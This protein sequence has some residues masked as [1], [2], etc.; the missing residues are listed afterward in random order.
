MSRFLMFLL[1]FFFVNVSG[2]LKG[3]SIS[4]PINEGLL[5]H[6]IKEGIDSV[7]RL[8]N[9]SSLANDSILYVA[10]KHHAR[11]LEKKNKLSHYE[12]GNIGY[13]TPQERA[14][15]YG[16][17]PNYL[18]GENVAQNYYLKA[19]GKKNGE[20]T[21]HRSYKTLAK[22][23]VTQWVNSPGHFKNIIT[24]T[25]NTTGLAV[26][27]NPLD[28]SVFAVQ[29]FG[30]ALFQYQFQESKVF[31]PYSNYKPSLP[32]EAFDSSHMQLH[33]GKH[34]WNTKSSTNEERYI[35]GNQI[36]DAD[37]RILK[38]EPKGRSI[39]VYTKGVEHLSQIIKDKKDGL[40]IEV[41]KYEEYHC[42]N[43]EYYLAQ[44]RRNKQCEYSGLLLKPAYFKKLN[45]RIQY[46][47]GTKFRS[48]DRDYP[49]Y[50]AFFKAFQPSLRKEFKY[51]LGRLPRNYGGYLEFNLVY[52]NQKEVIRVRHLTD[53]CGNQIVDFQI[54]PFVYNAPKDTL[55]YDLPHIDSTYFF[56]FPKAIAEYQMK[57]ITPLLYAGFERYIINDVEIEAYSSIEGL[58]SINMQ[59]QIDRANSIVQAL[60]SRQDL[61]LNP[62]IETNTNW[63][64]FKDQL[65]KSKDY[66]YLLSYHETV[67]KQ[68]VD[69]LLGLDSNYASLELML[70]SQ[71]YASIKLS[72]YYNLKDYAFEFFREYHQHYMEEFQSSKEALNPALDNKFGSLLS[73]VSKAI[74]EGLIS[75][76]KLSYF[77]PPRHKSMPSSLYA[78]F[79]L[80]HQFEILEEDPNRWT[81][82]YNLVNVPWNPIPAGLINNAIVEQFNNYREQNTKLVNM[83]E[84]MEG[85][86][87]ELS[88]KENYETVADSFM[89]AL[90]ID[91]LNEV[92]LMGKFDI[93]ERAANFVFEFYDSRKVDSGELLDIAELFVFI[94]DYNR[95]YKLLEPYVDINNPHLG[96]ISL[97]TKLIYQNSNEYPGTP[98]GDW[99]KKIYP[100]FPKEQWCQ[101]FVGPCNISF[102]VFDDKS[103][104]DLYCKQCA[105]FG[106]YAI[107]PPT[108]GAVELK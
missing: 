13:E 25:Y 56:Y 108:D 9:L 36:I 12:R 7:R 33:K 2:Q 99:L 69:S 54:P 53:V 46:R 85:H 43:P 70:D 83:A 84:N 59:L 48:W 63:K 79:V 30:Q 1:L 94:E 14:S 75:K 96:I 49:F 105:E 68:K 11:Y 66:K 10:A 39:K 23:I 17:G 61:L 28:R 87:L 74:M 55:V 102:Q 16:I 15:S 93:F 52:L 50:T 22:A 58:N 3:Q 100:L 107:N 73:S 67:Q 78:Y 44:S 89:L 40:A 32:I 37:P 29:K 92:E 90:S 20:V 47:Y 57:D 27:I 72:A 38:I 41:M 97:Y 106:N 65:Q 101:L 19:V 62:K 81:D 51:R 95:A 26:A 76:G 86:I 77:I 4:E 91:I 88:K 98:Y 6:F 18:V 31:F 104:R 21:I 45:P 8:H 5:G 82:L 35:R 103:V 42:G 71:R 34:A 64:L 24:P 60:Q 80:L